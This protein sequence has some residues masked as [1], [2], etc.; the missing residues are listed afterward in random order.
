MRHS[1]HSINIKRSA[2]QRSRL[3]L[4]LVILGITVQGCG[5]G[6]GS[7]Q[8]QCINSEVVEQRVD[9]DFVVVSPLPPELGVAC[10]SGSDLEAFLVVP[11]APTCDLVV[12]QA[13]VRGCCMDY[14]TNQSVQA[15]L[16]FR[17]GADSVPLGSQTKSVTLPEQT[18]PSIALSFENVEFDPGSYDLDSDG[19]SNVEEYCD[20]TL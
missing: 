9:V 17:R 8:A 14:P 2:Q 18:T 5:D 13:E 4:C 10:L 15:D 6:D 3:M 7:S 16:Y 20:G 11:G 19:V 1:A 12:T